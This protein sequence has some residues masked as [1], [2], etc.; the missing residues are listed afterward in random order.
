MKNRSLLFLISC[1][2]VLV[3]PG[4]RAQPSGGKKPDVLVGPATAKLGST[5][6]IQLPP[7]YAFL[8]GK[9][10]RAMMKAAGF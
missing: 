2:V 8:D 4:L 10:T 9:T 7:G 6:Q 1:A 3:A 5:A